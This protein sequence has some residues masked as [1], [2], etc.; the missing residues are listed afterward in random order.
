[1]GV[2]G[3]TPY[4]VQENFILPSQHV[5]IRVSQVVQKLRLGSG[6]GYLWNTLSKQLICVYNQSITR[7]LSIYCR[8]VVLVYRS[9][10]NY[11]CSRTEKSDKKALE[12]QDSRIYEVEPDTKAAA[13]SVSTTSIFNKVFAEEF[14]LFV[15]FFSDPST[16]WLALLWCLWLVQPPPPS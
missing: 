11:S 4:Y 10:G 15:C 6:N 2:G 8:L 14:I 13:E 3:E 5:P 16:L 9:A 1:M 7:E 12:G